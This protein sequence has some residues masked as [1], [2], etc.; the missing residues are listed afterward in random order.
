MLLVAACHADNVKTVVKNLTGESIR[1]GWTNG[2]ASER[3]VFGLGETVALLPE[4]QEFFVT[5]F[6]SDVAASFEL[7]GSS[8]GVAVQVHRATEGANSYCILLVEERGSNLQF[9]YWGMGLGIAI[10]GVAFI[11]NNVAKVFKTAMGE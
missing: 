10:C 7:D 5:V 4:G 6:D 1:M 2:A 8:T 9:A 3:Y 11:R